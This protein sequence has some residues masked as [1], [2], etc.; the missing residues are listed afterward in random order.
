MKW[1]VGTTICFSLCTL[2]VSPGLSRDSDSPFV[3]PA[4]SDPAESLRRAARLMHRLRTEPPV[5]KQ[6]LDRLQ[7]QLSDRLTKTL[8]SMERRSQ[9][10]QSQSHGGGGRGRKKPSPP[11]PQ[12][13]S[14]PR[15]QNDSQN[16][17]GESQNPSG[18]T[19]S[20]KDPAKPPSGD[21]PG[22]R[23]GQGDG[24]GGTGKE[25][26]PAG[27]DN[28]RW[29]QLPPKVRDALETN[30]G[31][32]VPEEVEDDMKDFNKRMRELDQ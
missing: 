13:F 14:P 25:K 7:K 21:G 17:T 16:Q 28:D 19:D 32:D 3:D 12:R 2:V 22:Q 11:R 23:P 10:S 1:F 29:G 26:T 30:L 31:R 15:R 9:D 20:Q 18:P 6:E 8:L 24:S 4:D 27:N 5:D